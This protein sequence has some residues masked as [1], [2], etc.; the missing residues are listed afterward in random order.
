MKWPFTFYV[1]NLPVNVGGT[2]NGFV[3]RI[4]EKYRHDEG[5]YRHEL[6]HV[7]QW[8]VW[9]LLSIPVAYALYQ[10][11]LFDYLALAILPCALPS[12]LY[13]FVTSYRLWC[14]VE[15]YKEQARFYFDDR[16]PLFAEYI[17]DSYDLKITPEQALKHLKD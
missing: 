7:K 14:E 10:L 16:R 9:S 3:I 13:R 4:L 15:A 11:A 6:M 17:A 1:R 8:A 12:A 5:I 2:T